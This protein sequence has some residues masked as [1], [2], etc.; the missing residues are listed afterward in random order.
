VSQDGREFYH[1]G[2]IDF[3]QSYNFSK[4]F[5][6]F[7]KTSKKNQALLISCVDPRTYAN[8]F[9]NFCIKNVVGETYT[10]FE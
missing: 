8:R 4:R 1:L 2:I 7:V 10:R 6:T 5:E 3:L 9:V